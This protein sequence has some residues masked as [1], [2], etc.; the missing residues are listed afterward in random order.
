MCN[1][2]PGNWAKHHWILLASSKESCIKVKDD[3]VIAG[4][5]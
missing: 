5:K 1:S 2:G 3:K 4:I